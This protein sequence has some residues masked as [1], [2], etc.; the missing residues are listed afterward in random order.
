LAENTSLKKVRREH[1]VLVIGLGR[2]GAAL[3]DTLVSLGHDVLG[4]DT[5]AHLVQEQSALLT[6]VLQAD[7]TNPETLRQIGANEF[8]HVV[9]AIGNVEASVLTVAELIAMGVTDIWA[10]ALNEQHARI[11]ERI[12]AKKVVQPEHDAGERMAHQVTGK[13]KEY[14]RLDEGFAL[15][16]VETPAELIGK[17]LGEAGVRAK[18]DV[19]IVCIKPPGGSFTYATPDTMLEKGS[20]LLVAGE[21]DRAEAFA[22]RT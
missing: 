4:I 12:G 10:K 3:A 18:Y 22:E 1:E 16:E 8:Q 13:V 15:V 7:A 21:G 19:T 14:I 2:F 6:N 17:T 20:V 9:V 5:D 11:L